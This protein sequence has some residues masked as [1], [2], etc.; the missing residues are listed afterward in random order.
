MAWGVAGIPAFRVV[1]LDGARLERE[2]Y[3]RAACRR[4]AGLFGTDLARHV[5]VRTPRHGSAMARSL[6]SSLGSLRA[7]LPSRGQ[8]RRHPRAAAG[9]R[10]ARG[11]SFDDLDGRAGDC[12]SGD[13]HIRRVSR[14]PSMGDASIWLYSIGHPFHHFGRRLDYARIRRCAWFAPW[15]CLDASLLFLGAYAGVCWD[16]RGGFRRP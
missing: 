16:H 11:S 13:R 7:S 8:F 2:K 5:C 3:P 4:A 10:L 12:P 1:R 15:R 14:N 9:G 6:G